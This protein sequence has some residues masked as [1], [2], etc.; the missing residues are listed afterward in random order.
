MSFSP[1]GVAKPRQPGDG[2]RQCQLGA[3]ARLCLGRVGRARSG[4]CSFLIAR[5]LS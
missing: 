5:L 1:S 4:K 2:C 3:P